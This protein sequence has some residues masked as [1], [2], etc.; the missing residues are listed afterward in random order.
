M[1]FFVVKVQQE[2]LDTDVAKKMKPIVFEVKTREEIDSHFS[3][4]SYGK[5]EK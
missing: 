4:S 3:Y 5:G 1:D 2:V